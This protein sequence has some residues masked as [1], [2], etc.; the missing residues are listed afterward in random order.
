MLYSKYCDLTC[1]L[2]RKAYL[3]Y[4]KYGLAMISSEREIV[5]IL[6][7][8]LNQMPDSHADVT[9]ETHPGQPDYDAQVEGRISGKNVTFLVEAKQHV[10]PRDVHQY[11]S[12]AR[13]IMERAKHHFDDNMI[14]LLAACSI[15]PGAKKLLREE[16]CAYFDAGGSLY[17]AANGL[18][19]D[20]ERPPV[21]SE[22]RA[23]RSLFTGTRARVLLTMLVHP[24]KWKSVKQVG[25]EA[26]VSTATA[27]SV[28]QALEMNDWVVAEGSGPHKRRRVRR[29]SEVL[30][31]WTKFI[32]TRKPPKHRR[33]YIPIRHF[34]DMTYKVPQAFAAH[35]VEYELTGEAAAQ[36]YSPWLTHISVLRFR[37]VYSENAEAA[38]TELKAQLTTEGSNL[39]VTEVTSA[40]EL[41]HRREE[42]GLWYAHPIQVYLDLLKMEGRARDAAQHLRET[43]IG[44]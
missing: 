41:V 18:L 25:E 39:W 4:S 17:V 15:S 23:I 33:Y 7:G 12:R 8:T 29:P 36:H 3:L 38:L 40:K 44:F 16:H 2:G 13:S 32:E 43:R 26:N 27:S 10:Y 24:D 34:D 42:G 35:A 5:Q 11:L 28:L 1:Y 14:L 30:D 37:L 21:A 19:I 20:R 31:A 9:M 6:V 22:A